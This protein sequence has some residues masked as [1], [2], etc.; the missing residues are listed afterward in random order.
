VSL[1]SQQGDAGIEARAW[2]ARSRGFAAAVAVIIA[3]TGGAA[4][5]RL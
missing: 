2:G 3:A 1:A 5:P 4:R